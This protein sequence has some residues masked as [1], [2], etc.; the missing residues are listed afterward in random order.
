[1]VVVA[2]VL[3]LVITGV[4]RTSPSHFA[5]ND[6]ATGSFADIFTLDLATARRIQVTRT[7]D[8]DGWP[9]WGRG[10]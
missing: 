4:S 9:T 7:P 6:G 10:P 5:T 1:L 8:L 3:T 2:V